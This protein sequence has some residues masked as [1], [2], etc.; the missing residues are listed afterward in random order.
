MKAII[1]VAMKPET[2]HNHC[3][4]FC[5]PR[6]CFVQ[7]SWVW[8]PHK[9]GHSRWSRFGTLFCQEHRVLVWRSTKY[10]GLCYLPSLSLKMSCHSL[11]KDWNRGFHLH[12]AWSVFVSAPWPPC[13]H[14]FEKQDRAHAKQ[15]EQSESFDCL[16]GFVLLSRHEADQPERSLQ[17]IARC[18]LRSGRHE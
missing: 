4:S 18:T 1:H 5:S 14:P 2:F 8:E 16:S 17:S 13:L 11:T 7:L 6:R 12:T 10:L 3:V 15:Y 9:L